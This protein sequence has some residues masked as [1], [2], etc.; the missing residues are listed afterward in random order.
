MSELI[1]KD[2]YLDLITRRLN[3]INRKTVAY[4]NEKAK[5]RKAYMES[6]GL[7]GSIDYG[8]G[9]N[10]SW[11]NSELAGAATALGGPLSGMMV[12]SDSP[13]EQAPNNEYIGEE[14]YRKHSGWISDEMTP[15][16]ISVERKIKSDYDNSRTLN[17]FLTMSET[18]LYVD[19]RNME[20]KE[21]HIKASVTEYNIV[22]EYEMYVDIDFISDDVEVLGEP[23]VIDGS[24]YVSVYDDNNKVAYGILS[25]EGYGINFNECI[26]FKNNKYRLLCYSADGLLEKNKDYD[27]KLEWKHIWY[28]RAF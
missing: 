17:N 11:N 2:K 21:K 20:E 24:Y 27:V 22:T 16:M 14:K 19:T 25:G 18:N 15:A 9:P 8:R 7:M 12:I 23:A 5:Q 26:G 1:G 3:E 6:H 10:L 28:A 4:E 13:Y